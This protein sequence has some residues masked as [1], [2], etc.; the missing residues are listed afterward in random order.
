MNEMNE[1]LV[2]GGGIV[3]VCCALEMQRRGARVVLVDRKAPGSETSYGNAGVFST[4]SLVP[5]NNPA[6]FASL[7]GLLKNRGQSF[8]YDL[9]YLM[10]MAGWGVRFLLNARRSKFEETAAALHALISLSTVEHMRLLR[11]A[12]ALHRLRDTGWMTLYRD[13]AAFQAGSLAR[14]TYDRFAISYKLLDQERIAD[15]EPSL[16]RGFHCGLWFD[17]AMSVDSPGAVTQAYAR[18]FADRGG[19][20]MQAEAAA[21]QVLDGKRWQL[22]TSC[23]K[24]LLAQKIVVALGPWTNDLLRTIGLRLPMAFERGYHM[25]YASENGAKLNRPVYDAAGGYVLSPMEQGIRMTT[26]V[27]LNRR[28]APPDFAQLER[29]EAA[30]RRAFPLARRLDDV[31]WLGRR[32]TLPDSRPAIGEVP[33]RR[34]LWLACGHQHIGF[35]TGTGTAALLGAMMHGESPPIDPRPFLASRFIR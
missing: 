32:P 26:G 16:A 29:C 10:Q 24:R 25:H 31:P 34:G 21:L 2:V 14:H 5:F 19:E 35:S 1:V 11:E 7:P 23:G 30:A 20:L 33:R 8:R 3:G 15:L 22:T 18:V 28:D 13:Q 17:G 9:G 27:E 4:S 6:L 12:Q